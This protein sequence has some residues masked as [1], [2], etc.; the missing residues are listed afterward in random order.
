MKRVSVLFGLLLLGGLRKRRRTKSAVTFIVFFSGDSA[1]LTPE[2]QLIVKDAASHIQ[3]TRPATVMIAAGVK[4]GGTWIF[5]SRAFRPFV[6]SW[7]RMALSQRSSHAHPF[8]AR[9]SRLSMAAFPVAMSAPRS[10]C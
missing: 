2:A 8:R 10:G 3:N 1:K 9:S 5:P 7:L 4:A 6:K